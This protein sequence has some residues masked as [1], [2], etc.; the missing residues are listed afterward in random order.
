MSQLEDFCTAKELSKKWN[1]SV[2]MIS[3]YCSEGRIPGAK[4]LGKNWII[5]AN[6]EKPV[7]GRTKEG[8]KDGK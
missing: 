4:L 7:D 3:Y 6:A 2:R 1:V 5:P 8:K